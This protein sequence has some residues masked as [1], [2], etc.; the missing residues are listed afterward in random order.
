MY[1][2]RDHIPCMGQFTRAACVIRNQR[3][4]RVSGIDIRNGK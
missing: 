4:M 2:T 1:N 3:G